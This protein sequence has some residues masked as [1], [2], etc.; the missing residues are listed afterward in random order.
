MTKIG[1]MLLFFVTSTL[2]C[3]GSSDDDEEIA[4]YRAYLNAVYIKRHFS[5]ARF[6]DKPFDLI[7]IDD[8][9]AGFPQPFPYKGKI[10][11]LKPRPDES[12][13]QSF[14][15]RNDANR[16]K[17]S[18]TKDDHQTNGRYPLS[19][20]LKF[21]LSHVL[22]AQGEFKK[23]LTAG[24][25]DEFY[26]RFPGSRGM[27]WFSRVGFNKDRTQAL[28]YFGNQYTDYAGEGYL[29][30]MAKADGT[31]REVTRVTVWIS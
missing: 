19:S 25:W 1:I 24:G 10:E 3:Y 31:W 20:R 7:V 8:Q 22:I 27:I 5:D 30:L 28:F 16:P 29:I 21:D 2:G 14:L 23:I 11:Q 26:R 9:T 17:S 6:A 15:T 18:S 12:T 13:T 4:V